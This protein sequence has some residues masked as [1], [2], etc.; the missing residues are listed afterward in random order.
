MQQEYLI[1]VCIIAAGFFLWI[2]YSTYKHAEEKEKPRLKMIY[3]VL[4]IVSILVFGGIMGYRYTHLTEVTPQEQKIQ[5]GDT[6]IQEAPIDKKML[7]KTREQLENDPSW[8]M[9]Q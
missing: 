7:D 9:W 8:R 3:A 2:F 5:I 4:G 6:E 1:L